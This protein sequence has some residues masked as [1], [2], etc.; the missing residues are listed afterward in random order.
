MPPYAFLR[1]HKHTHIYKFSSSKRAK[2][3]FTNMINRAG[4]RRVNLSIFFLLIIVCAEI[5]NVGAVLQQ[6]RHEIS[7]KASGI[8]MTSEAKEKEKGYI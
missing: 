8:V 6:Q 5:N 4:N 1:K 7:S 2:Q 3:L